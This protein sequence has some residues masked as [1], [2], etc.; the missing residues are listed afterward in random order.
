MFHS[1]YQYNV[2]VFH[3][4]IIF[5]IFN[6]YIRYPICN[7]FIFFTLKSSNVI[8]ILSINSFI[9]SASLHSSFKNIF[10]SNLLFITVFSTF[11]INSLI[12]SCNFKFSSI[13]LLIK[14]DWSDISLFI[15]WHVFSIS[16][17]K[18]Y[19]F[20]YDY[21]KTLYMHKIFRIHI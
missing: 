16:L 14:V 19:I 9:V 4:L 20:F 12:W 10:R 13:N 6:K 15:I 21:I 5:Y 3:V 8:L 2:M 17:L 7:P 11:G 1:C 18:I